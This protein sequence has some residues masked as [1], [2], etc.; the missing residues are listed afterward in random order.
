MSVYL[1]SPELTHIT[2]LVML[3][4]R[5]VFHLGQYFWAT[6]KKWA[7]RKEDKQGETIGAWWGRQWEGHHSELI[8]SFTTDLWS[9]ISLEVDFSFQLSCGFIL[10]PITIVSKCLPSKIDR[11][12]KIF[13]GLH[14]GRNF[15]LLGVKT[16]LCIDLFKD[17]I[18]FL[19]FSFF[20]LLHF[21]A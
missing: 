10:P 16:L 2:S 3:G 19:S 14:G 12:S 11:K 13:G 18:N 6:S 1:S 5:K 9:L 17:F 15:S 8:N 7:L 4:V 21:L 20:S